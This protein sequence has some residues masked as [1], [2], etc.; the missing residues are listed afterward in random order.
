MEIPKP[1][2]RSKALFKVFSIGA[3]LVASFVASLFVQSM[4]DDRIKYQ[5]MALAEQGG[6]VSQILI[7]G[8]LPGFDAETGVSVYRLVD[9]VLKY[10]ILF[11]TLTFLVFFLMEIFYQL[12][13]HPIQYLLVGLALAEFYLLLLALM[14]HIGF[15]LAY[16]TAA[17]LT[18]SL[19]SFYSNFILRSPKGALFVGG[20]LTV[21]YTYLFLVLHL[22]TYALLAGALLLFA[23]LA[24]IMV[25]TRNLNWYEAFGYLQKVEAKAETGLIR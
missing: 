21:V 19:V 24:T 10:A 9:R 13:L 6:D 17:L 15:L 22:E 20:A 18:I 4:V 1:P 3:V 7:H 12:N 16:L 8:T 5:A 2:T 11:I 14:E 25:I 23:L